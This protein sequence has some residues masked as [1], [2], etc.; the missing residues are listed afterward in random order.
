M[1]RHLLALVALITAGR[2]EPDHPH[3]YAPERPWAG[4][5]CGDADEDALV[6]GGRAGR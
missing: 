5:W 2:L 3:R 6:H 1:I 4:C